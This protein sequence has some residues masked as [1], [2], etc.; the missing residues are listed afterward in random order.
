M[1]AIPTAPPTSRVVSLT[2]EP[3]PA[4]S[5]GSDRTIPVDS[6]GNANAE[7][8]ET[9]TSVT[10]NKMYGVDSLTNDIARRPTGS[11]QRP[12]RT[13]RRGSYFADSAAPRGDTST[14]VTAKG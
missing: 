5:I 9:T 6:V 2:A 8:V 7:P 13:T 11:R 14:I 10:A 1:R 12:A 3:T 4:L